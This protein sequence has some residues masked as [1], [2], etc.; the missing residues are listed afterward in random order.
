MYDLLLFELYLAAALFLLVS[1]ELVDETLLEVR[2]S[3]ETALVPDE[4]RLVEA[5]A[6]LVTAL[7]L[8]LKY[9]FPTF[10]AL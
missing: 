2:V 7:D 1:I 9:E 8:L 10:P 4:L 6:D 3:E 5:V